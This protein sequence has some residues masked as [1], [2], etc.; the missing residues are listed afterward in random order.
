MGTG[1][2]PG[3]SKHIAVSSVTVQ[4]GRTLTLKSPLVYDRN[5]KSLT[6]QARQAVETF[7]QNKKSAAVENVL[8]TDS[9]GNQIYTN[10]G[11]RNSVSHPAIIEGMAT[12]MT[13][14]HPRPGK[15]ENVLGGTFSPE[16]IDVLGRHISTVKTIRATAAEGTYSMSIPPTVRHRT[17]RTMVADYRQYIQQIQGKYTAVNNAKY[18]DYTNG[19]CRYRD[20]KSQ[21]NHSMNDMLIDLHNWLRNNQ[22]KYGYTYTLEQ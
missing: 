7:E 13:H 3:G 16:D 10:I 2:S 14:N 6:K 11:G 12:V 22:K 21:C 1:S 17:M 20:Y 9:N 5:D 18:T 8:F 19:L 4:N 15:Y